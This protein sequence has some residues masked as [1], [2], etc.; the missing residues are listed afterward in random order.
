MPVEERLGAADSFIGQQLSDP[1]RQRLFEVARGDADARVR[2]NAWRALSGETEHKEIHRAMLARLSDENPE[3]VERGGALI[4][5]AYSF[6]DKIRKYAETMYESPETR[7]FALEAMRR[8]LDRSFAPYFPKHLEDD[9]FEVKRQAIWGV[10]YLG[11]ADAA[12]KLKR[13]FDDEDLRPD[14]LFA[15][16]LSTRAE[17]SRGRMKGL[18]RKIDELAGLSEHEEELVKGALD[19]RLRL[20]GLEPVFNEE[21]EEHVHGP[22]CRH[23]PISEV[24]PPAAI[25]VGRNDPCP[26]GSG[27]KYKKC[28]GA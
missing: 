15:Y 21:E 24:I 17:T 19:E 22:D 8:S 26:C 20:Y 5:L 23:E 13:L 7:A 28:C 2:G 1:A 6:D 16:A 10:G 25:K 18:L 14:A 12:E 3:A 27:K 4:G 11:I 9:N